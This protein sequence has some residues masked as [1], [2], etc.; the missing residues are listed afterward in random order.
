MN[1]I[2]L[3]IPS[4]VYESWITGERT[5]SAIAADYGVSPVTVKRRLYKI[6]E[7][8]GDTPPSPPLSGGCPV[9][10]YERWR[11]G[12]PVPALAEEMGVAYSSLRVVL[13]REMRRRKDSRPKKFIPKGNE[14]RFTF[15][16]DED[17]YKWIAENSFCVSAF[18]REAI[19]EKINRAKKKTGRN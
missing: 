10:I 17:V 11:K 9:D 18:I 13:L 2:E 15:L 14:R 12:E 8:K 19:D 5:F 3:E 6:A 7:D 4:D 16:M 1:T